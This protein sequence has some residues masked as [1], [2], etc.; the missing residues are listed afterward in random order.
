MAAIRYTVNIKIHAERKSQ[1]TNHLKTTSY[2]FVNDFTKNFTKSIE[3]VGL[4]FPRIRIYFHARL[5]IFSHD[6]HTDSGGA[7]AA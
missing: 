3:C 7:L 5:F 1:L 4:A 6:I 2:Q